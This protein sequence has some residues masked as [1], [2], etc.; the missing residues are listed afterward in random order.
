MKKFASILLTLLLAISCTFALAA[1]G[2]PCKDG[3]KGG[4]ATCT[5]KAVCEVC[6]KEYGELLPHTGGVA[7]CKTKATC[8]VCNQQYGELGY[9]D[10]TVAANRILVWRG[11][12]ENIPVTSICKYCDEISP[13]GQSLGNYRLISALM[14]PPDHPNAIKEFYK[15]IFDYTGNDASF[16]IMQADKRLEIGT[17]ENARTCTIDDSRKDPADIKGE[18][19][20]ING[21]LILK[22]NVNTSGKIIVKAGATLTIEEGAAII[23]S[24]EIIIEQGGHLV[25]EES[26]VTGTAIVKK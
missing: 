12:G 17:S 8:S 14:N 13:P 21:N 2:D 9:H 26:S 24:G 11:D 4:T 16:S 18:I 23:N 1:C 19:T 5:Q 7:T 22:G 3:H 20:V 15:V 6:E 10:F 25:G